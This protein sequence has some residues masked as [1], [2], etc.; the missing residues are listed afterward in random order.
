MAISDANSRKPCLDS[1]AILFTATWIF[2]LGRTPLYTFP[3][4]PDPRS[5]LSRKFLVAFFSS[6]YENLWGPTLNSH[7]SIKSAFLIFQIRKMTAATAK[8]INRVVEMERPRMRSL[9][10]LLGR[11]SEGSDDSCSGLA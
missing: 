4:P 5:S 2:D 6:L 11:G 10:L 9:W 8:I 7:A 1:C 3:N